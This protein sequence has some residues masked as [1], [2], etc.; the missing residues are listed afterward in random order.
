[1]PQLRFHP[2]HS[3]SLTVNLLRYSLVESLNVRGLPI[4]CRVVMQ[5]S[6]RS[7]VKKDPDS[8][9]AK[10]EFRRVMAGRRLR[11]RGDILKRRAEERKRNHKE[12]EAVEVDDIE[13]GEE[14][15]AEQKARIERMSMVERK[16][17]LVKG[18]GG[19]RSKS[20]KA[21]R[22]ENGEETKEPAK[23]P[24]QKAT[25][26]RNDLF[27]D[28]G[29]LFFCSPFERRIEQTKDHGEL[30][31]GGLYDEIVVNQHPDLSVGDVAEFGMADTDLVG[32]RGISGFKPERLD[33]KK[34][35]PV[36]EFNVKDPELA[37][38]SVLEGDFA[39]IKA[40][41]FLFPPEQPP[42]LEAPKPG[43]EDAEVPDSRNGDIFD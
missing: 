4:E 17:T 6:H 26:D 22:K 7:L 32:F 41:G 12:S 43:V 40:R 31:A 10:L 29:L 35:L 15:Q 27:S 34:F 14:G 39:A 11:K 37:Y 28:G 42:L 3:K 5:L 24:A 20:E 21:E 36:G 33:R 13:V 2:R 18:E 38:N 23:A 30:I 9:A 16:T 25:K 8:F 1:M 19:E